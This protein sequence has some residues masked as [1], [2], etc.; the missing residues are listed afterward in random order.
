MGRPTNGYYTKEGKRVPSVTTVLSRFKESGA[1]IHW[2]AG[3]AAE[4]VS[5][6]CPREPTREAVLRLCDDAKNAYREVK[7]QAA[8]AG[9]L[10]HA[11]VEN[12]IHGLPVDFSGFPE[13]ITGKAKTAFGSFLEWADQ[14]QLKVT[15]TETSL[16]SEKYGFAGTMDAIMIRGK[17]ACGDW[18]SSSG[19]Y[20]EYLIQVA[21]YGILW[22]ENHPDMPIDGGYHLIRFD[23]VYGDF[24]A[25]F[26]PELETAKKAFLLMRE[27]YEMDKE[28]K[29]RAK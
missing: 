8:D 27:L 24:H 7:Q 1:L 6:H 18:K 14:T 29:A 2:A 16:V 21:A 23:K 4:Y 12:W 10:A 9:M 13:E 25:H 28:L 15:E 17:R 22:E 26:W 3:Q 11:A 20:P 5:I 19:I